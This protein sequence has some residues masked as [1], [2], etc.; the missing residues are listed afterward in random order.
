MKTTNVDIDFSECDKEPIHLLGRIQSHGFLLAF[1]KGP[2]SLKYISQ[3]IN[4]VFDSSKISEQ[5]VLGDLFDAQV[6]Q[7]FD[8]LKDD[9]FYN[10]LYENKISIKGKQYLLFFSNSNEDIV[11]ELEAQSDNNTSYES[12]NLLKSITRDIKDCRTLENLA[13]TTA[14][15]LKDFTG[16]DRIMIYQ[17]DDKGDGEVIAEEKSIG[18]SSF[19]GLKYPATDIPKQARKLYLTNLSRSIHDTGD[20][21]IP[22]ES[23]KKSDN[24]LDLSYSVYRSVSPV[25]IQYLK[26]MGVA[27]THVVSIIIDNELWGM[28]ICHHYEGEKY[29]NFNSRFLLELIAGYFS[30]KISLLDIEAL[31]RHEKKHNDILYNINLHESEEGFESIL[32]DNWKGIKKQLDVCGFT[33]YNKHEKTYSHGITP[34]ASEILKI[35]NA[36]DEKW[37]SEFE[38]NIFYADSIKSM[39]KN[40]Q[41]NEVAGCVCLVISADLGKYVHFWKTAKEHVVNWAGNPEKAMTIEQKNDRMVLS[42]RSS[43]DIWKQK[44]KEKSLPWVPHQKVFLEKLHKLFIRKELKHYKNI[45]DEKSKL[46]KKGEQLRILVEEKSD[47]LERLNRKLKDQLKS[48]KKYQKQLEIALK[49][50]EEI[51]QLKSKILSNVSHE[52]RTPIT[53]IIG[54][55][56]IILMD[57]ELQ[58]NHKELIEMTLKSSERLL[59]TVN[60][61]LLASEVDSDYKSVHIEKV[62]IISF[63]ESIIQSLKHDA[64]KKQ[65]SL[66]F[67]H[68]NSELYFYTDQHYYSQILYNLVNNA[69]KYTPHNGKIE[70]N[71]KTIRKKDIDYVSL[72]VEDNGI[73]LEEDKIDRI[74]EPYFTIS[75]TTHQADKSTGLGLYIVKNNLKLLGG[76]I[77]LESVKGKGS[78]FKVLIPSKDE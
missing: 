29:L 27:A 28:L 17:F 6:V 37:E 46:A 22:V 25:H 1:S 78:I 60:K 21:G 45:F 10:V 73:G 40:W 63:S 58:P 52:I 9:N 2:K 4:E 49:T 77:S 64:D 3:N 55:S 47:E 70:V 53:S 61:I 74:F 20:E 8:K 7:F 16:F 76:D 54:I 71:V 72:T 57:A 65:I 59:N 44:E 12:F 38:K 42:P 26:N 18:L 13:N 19:L 5:T 15:F 30:N 48:N 39:L 31:R 24:T 14:L 33:V 75:D 56:K 51:N 35:H 23:L 32:V 11:I 36:I 34:E 62:E 66:I 41:N 43:F 67:L 50:G 68:Q 69:I